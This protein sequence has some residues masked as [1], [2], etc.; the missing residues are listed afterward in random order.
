MIQ[1]VLVKIDEIPDKIDKYAFKILIMQLASP[2]YIEF[3]K[4][5]KYAVLRFKN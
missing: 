2:Q 1:N 4:F 3:N 5:Y